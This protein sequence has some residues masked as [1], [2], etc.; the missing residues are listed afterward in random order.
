MVRRLDLAAQIMNLSKFRKKILFTSIFGLF[1]FSCLAV[2]AKEPTLDEKIGQMITIGFH[3][4]SASD[5]EVKT[6]LQ[7]VKS[8]QI[9]GVM[10]LKYNI[11]NPQQLKTLTANLKLSAKKIPLLISVD[12]EGGRVQRLG[13]SNGFKDYPSP[14][15]VAENLTPGEAYDLYTEMSQTLKE[16]DI[17]VNF[18]PLVDV[19]VNPESPVIGKKE[20]SFSANPE[21]VAVYARATVLGHRNN[22]VMTSLK[23]FP[24]HGSAGTDTHLQFTDV[25]DTWAEQELEPYKR[26][27]ALN[28]ADMI[29]SS[30]IFN[31]KIDDQ[32]PASISEKTVNGLLRKQLG[33]HGVVVTD[34][35]QMGAISNNFK[36]EDVIVSAV[37]AG[38]DILLFANYFNPDPM[39]PEKVKLI[40]KQAVKDGRISQQEIDDSYERII[41]LKNRLQR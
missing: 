13:A 22:N 1:L 33:Y 4:T 25:T 27:I 16:Y 39:I 11:E 3:G 23:H 31:K 8:G 12:Q 17:N 24:G 38:N 20:R 6:V 30:H 7:Q 2:N 35:L 32:Y 5:A 41:E 28:N 18:A 21:T 19:D 9:G 26:L 14:K 29:M 10:L 37:N 34:D 40:I 36:F 15:Y